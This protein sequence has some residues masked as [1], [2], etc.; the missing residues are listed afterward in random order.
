MTREELLQAMGFDNICNR[1][2]DK[3]GGMGTRTYPST[4][5]WRGGIGGQ[6]LTEGMCDVCWGSGS[7]EW[8]GPDQRKIEAEMKAMKLQIDEW[9]KCGAALRD[10]MRERLAQEGLEMSDTPKSHYSP[11][12]N[13]LLELLKEAK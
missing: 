5:Q 9:R 2:C 6:A 8:T 12:C 10:E 3:C 13:R 11:T 4:A 7:K 1:P